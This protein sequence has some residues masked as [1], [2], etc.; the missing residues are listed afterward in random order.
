MCPQ[1]YLSVG[2]L[3]QN[4]KPNRFY[5]YEKHTL[6]KY[7]YEDAEFKHDFKAE[8]KLKGVKLLQTLKHIERG[9]VNPSK[10][11]MKL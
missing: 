1:Q 5:R 3:Q 6:R 9:S 4:G 7:F 2:V 10:F 8:L 11:D